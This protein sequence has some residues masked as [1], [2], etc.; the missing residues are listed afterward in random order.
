MIKD[1]N[2]VHEALDLKPSITNN[3]NT[4]QSPSPQSSPCALLY[5]PTTYK[6]WQAH[7]VLLRLCHSRLINTSEPDGHTTL[8]GRH[9][10]AQVLCQRAH[11]PRPPE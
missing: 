8:Q 4:H 7:Q 5:H 1:L 3:K 9:L 10:K 2:N 6:A 11:S